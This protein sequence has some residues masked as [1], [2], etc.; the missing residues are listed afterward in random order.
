MELPVRCGSKLE[1]RAV[2]RF[3]CRAE[4]NPVEIY[5]LICKTY[6][7]DWAFI[8]IR[9]ANQIVNLNQFFPP[10]GKNEHSSIFAILPRDTAACV[11]ALLSTGEKIS[12]FR[13]SNIKLPR[14]DI[15]LASFFDFLKNRRQAFWD[16]P[17]IFNWHSK[18]PNCLTW[19]KVDLLPDIVKTYFVL[20]MCFI[21]Y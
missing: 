1:V 15:F 16:N 11:R 20:F 6:G 14:Q 4:G 8:T 13:H 12:V 2:V 3:F 17:R 7:D 9:F 10:H 21:L 19:P 18:F 5:H